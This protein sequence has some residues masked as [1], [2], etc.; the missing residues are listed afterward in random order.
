MLLQCV[1]REVYEIL[2]DETLQSKNSENY[3]EIYVKKTLC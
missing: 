3:I 1:K 2:L